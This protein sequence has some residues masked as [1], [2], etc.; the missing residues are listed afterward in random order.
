MKFLIVVYFIRFVVADLNCDSFVGY[1]EGV[2]Q[3][4]TTGYDPI[5]AVFQIK[6]FANIQSQTIFGWF[7]KVDYSATDPNLYL[8]FYDGFPYHDA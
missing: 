3:N 6:M 4:L 8:H 7:D 1:Y 2:F 5:P